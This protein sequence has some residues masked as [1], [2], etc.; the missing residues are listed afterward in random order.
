MP[1]PPPFK[2]FSPPP[3]GDPKAEILA[4]L[5]WTA[6]GIFRIHELSRAN[7]GYSRAMYEH[8]VAQANQAGTQHQQPVRPGPVDQVIVGLGK[9]AWKNRT[10]I[11]RGLGEFFGKGSIFK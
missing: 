2:Q 7:Y 6:D 5:E 1:P 8:Q 3:G 4:F 9:A 10:K 11:G